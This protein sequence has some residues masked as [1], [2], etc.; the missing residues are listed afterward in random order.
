MFILF[1]LLFSY[2]VVCDFYPI[3]TNK[4]QTNLGLVISVPEIVLIIWV[5]F[6]AVDELQEVRI[7]CYN[8][9]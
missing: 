3:P 8:N 6:F 2:V 7:I 1:L 9:K 4:N 5:S